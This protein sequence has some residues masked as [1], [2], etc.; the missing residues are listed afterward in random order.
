MTGLGI[1]LAGIVTPSYACEL[2]E[3]AFR[4][5]LAA[6]GPIVVTAGILLAYIL[7]TFVRWQVSRP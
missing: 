6:S 4:G 5:S 7:G 2:S 3:P 1:G